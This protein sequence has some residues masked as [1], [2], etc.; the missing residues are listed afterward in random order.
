MATSVTLYPSRTAECFLTT[1][2]V[3]MT[4]SDSRRDE[5]YGILVVLVFICADQIDMTT[6]EREFT[7]LIVK[8][9]GPWLHGA[10]RFGSNSRDLGPN[11]CKALYQF[12]PNRNNIIFC[13][14]NTSVWRSKESLCRLYDVKIGWHEFRNITY[15]PH[16]K[17]ENSKFGRSLL[18]KLSPL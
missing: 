15:N 3:Q 18:I 13:T 10:D 7:S 2:T 5:A 17:H 9:W 14:L 11:V 8:E 12:P 1:Y 16:S 6:H 4:C